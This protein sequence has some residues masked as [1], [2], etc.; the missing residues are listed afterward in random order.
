MWSAASV[1]AKVLSIKTPLVPTAMVKDFIFAKPAWEM[2]PSIKKV[3]NVLAAEF[4]D[5][6]TC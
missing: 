1:T 4:T 6:Q 3:I 5:C 2:G